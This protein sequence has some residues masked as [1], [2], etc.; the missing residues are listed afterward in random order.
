MIGEPTDPGRR[1]IA[2]WLV[3]A[4]ALALQVIALYAPASPE[5]GPFD[6][7]GADKIAHFLLFA[8]PT[9]ALLRVVP[10]PWMA[11]APMLLHVPVSEVV[12]HLWLPG[13][14]GDW[15]DAA[16]DLLGIAVG[17]WTARRP[18]PVDG[19]ADT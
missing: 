14:D 17:W 9:W 12:Q 10:R 2:D 18:D 13:R 8:V 4:A 11:L 19:P 15:L 6:F 5:P 3:V 16:A 7:P 1:R